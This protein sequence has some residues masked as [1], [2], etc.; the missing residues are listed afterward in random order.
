MSDSEKQNIEDELED[1]T[2]HST[3]G[4]KTTKLDYYLWTKLNR[5]NRRNKLQRAIEITE[6]AYFA[7]K[8]KPEAPIN[9]DVVE[10]VF[11]VAQSLAS[12]QTKRINAYPFCLKCEVAWS[13]APTNENFDRYIS[14][15]LQTYPR[16]WEELVPNYPDIT[17]PRKALICLK[18]K[19]EL[20]NV[21]VDE[22]NKI[23]LLAVKEY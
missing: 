2:A 23:K 14:R 20:V 4:E 9:L 10:V 1:F 11:Q 8:M 13:F 5:S 18:C 12:A 22:E 17:E 6:L 7:K 3:R 16:A 21:A 15:W 19:G